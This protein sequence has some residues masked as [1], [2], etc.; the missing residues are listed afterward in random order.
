MMN[1]Q[2]NF[3]LKRLTSSGHLDKIDIQVIIRD[4][5]Q[6][7]IYIGTLEEN[8]MYEIVLK[9]DFCKWKS[10]KRFKMKLFDKNYVEILHNP[11]GFKWCNILSS[12]GKKML[13]NIIKK[14]GSKY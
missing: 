8:K 3:K 13:W 2:I 11:N 14:S 7:M 6:K 5:G 10:G 12:D 1:N 4:S 9:T